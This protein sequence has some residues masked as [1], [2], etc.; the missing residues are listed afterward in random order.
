MVKH[1]VFWKLQGNLDVRREFIREF[2]MKTKFLQTVIPQI[3]S[4]VVGENIYSDNGYHVCIDSIFESFEELE[5]YIS[6]PEHLKV[7]KFMDANT[8]DKTVFDY[9][10]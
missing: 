6:H 4:V 5:I 1:I 7:R 2:R 10:F 9:E 3:K 8:Y